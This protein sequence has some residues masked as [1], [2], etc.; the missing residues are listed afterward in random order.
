MILKVIGSIK[1]SIYSII[2]VL[3]SAIFTLVLYLRLSTH[4]FFFVPQ[5]KIPCWDI[6]I[7]LC[8]IFSHVTICI[9]MN[10]M[11]FFTLALRLVVRFFLKFLKNE[12]CSTSFH[13]SVFPWEGTPG[14]LGGKRYYETL[15]WIWYGWCTPEFRHCGCLNKIKPFN[16]L[17]QKRKEFMMLSLKHS[18]QL[19]LGEVVSVSSLITHLYLYL[20]SGK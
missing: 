8:V 11:F 18:W 1:T 16:I 4:P 2:Q 3:L 6:A 17:A 13:H 10:Q 7:K 9:Y 19:C 20:C 12:K 15:S 14:P 5:Q